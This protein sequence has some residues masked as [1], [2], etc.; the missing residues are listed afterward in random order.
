MWKRYQILK[1]K[2]SHP[3]SPYTRKKRKSMVVQLTTSFVK[4]DAI[5][6]AVAEISKALTKKGIN[7]CVVYETNNDWLK[8]GVNANNFVF[9]KD[10]IVIYHMAIGCDASN[11]FKNAKVKY[12]IIN[13]HNITPPKYFYDIPGMV[14]LLS[15]GRKQLKELKECTDL[16]ICDSA[17]NESELKAIGYSNTVVIPVPNRVDE[18][19]KLRVPKTIDSTIKLITVGRLA[20]NKCIEDV[21]KIYSEYEKLNSKSLLYIVGNCSNSSYL[22]ELKKLV[23]DLKIEKN[24]IFTGSINEKTLAHYY[25]N[26]DAYICMSEH[27]GFCVPLVEAA[28]FNLPIFAFSSSAIKETLQGYGIIFNEKNYKEIAYTLNNFLNKKGGNFA[29]LNNIGISKKYNNNTI[30]KAMVKLIEEIRMSNR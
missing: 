2:C 13:Y 3:F 5:G 4:K 26:A 23:S 7:N 9:K 8:N 6:N 11:I 22:E 30:L 25:S 10:D 1:F 19:L 20:R 21:I 18:L 16:A 17:F 24:V 15:L 28:R 14:E 12:K 29:S 27:E